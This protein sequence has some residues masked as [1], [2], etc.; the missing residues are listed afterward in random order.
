M[1]FLVLG[2]YDRVN[3]GDE[4][5]KI[6]FPKMFENAS[7]LVFKC[8]DDV[9]DTMDISV[10]DAVLCGGG[11]IINSYFMEKI[12]SLKAREYNVGIPFF[13]VAVG[14]PFPSDV[15][16]LGLF[17]HVFLRSLT[18]YEH[19]LPVLGERNV[20]YSPDAAFTLSPSPMSKMIKLDNKC[21][22]IV[23]SSAHPVFVENDH[24]LQDYVD[25]LEKL[26][27]S[28]S[29]VRPCVIHLVAFNMSSNAV[30]SDVRLN[31]RLHSMLSSRNVCVENHDD[32]DFTQPQ[33]VINFFSTMDFCV[34]MR[35]HSAVFA[36]IGKKP[37]TCLYI[38]QK[39]CNLL[40]DVKSPGRAHYQIPHDSD[41]RPESIDT[42]AALLA[43]SFAIRECP[44][45]TPR[46]E[47][48]EIVH[49]ISSL[50]LRQA[51]ISRI[52][53]IRRMFKWIS[54]YLIK[55]NKTMTEV[56][57][58]DPRSA[59]TIARILS[60]AATGDISSK[61]VW[62]LMNKLKNDPAH[63]MID[64]FDYIWESN[65]LIIRDRAITKQP[66]KC[67]QL[68]CGPSDDLSGYHRSGWEYAMS[69]FKFACNGVLILDN[70][71]DRTFSWA[72]DTL[73]AAGEIPYRKPWVGFVHHTFTEVCNHNMVEVFK[74]NNF[75]ES[76]KECK[77]L[78][79]LSKHLARQLRE[80]LVK[81]GFP[82][83]GVSSLVHPTETPALRFS[84]HRFECNK[85]R[86][87]VHI[88]AW[89]RK[90]FAIYDLPIPFPNDMSLTKAALKGKDMEAYFPPDDLM[91]EVP[92]GKPMTAFA[93]SAVCRPCR[94]GDGSNKFIQGMLESLAEKVDSVQIIHSLSNEE[95][96]RLLS[97]NIVFINL[98]DC[99]AVNTVIEC[100]VR[101]T[102]IFVNRLPA[103][104]EVLGHDYPG[105][106][107]DLLDAAKKMN[108]ET[109]LKITTFM[110]RL[111]K[112]HFSLA[113]FKAQFLATIASL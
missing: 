91:D 3:L 20:S 96:D 78:F 109:V 69:C 63:K 65:S 98:I 11:D 45:T 58:L 51:T 86:K 31:S 27:I 52:V 97:E 102:P 1:I 79:T 84:F 8:T 71:V 13:A 80:A 101:N 94:S 37:F 103:L 104:E 29:R 47:K 28:Q 68:L 33:F 105:F 55:I 7:Q 99:S 39:I 36:I 113:V 50:K 66:L 41:F 67:K 110:E 95:Y 44:V 100:I 18:D 75:I 64:S 35:Y 56:T 108:M 23:V 25:F 92:V 82:E 14:I 9:P 53:L 85:N 26:A 73:E 40:R 16:F 38:S 106:Y 88:G 89:L 2:Y 93:P 32:L 43:A 107:T 46:V 6:A 59:E 34:C 60:Y 62:G 70:F 12:K 74:N 42:G 57:S 48:H 24:L 87:V 90:P 77:H 5:Y 17:D 4:A 111:K 15:E 61:Y 19:A 10:Y 49:L 72:N 21:S 76:L 81:A 54:K 22:N 83:V 30:E 112:R